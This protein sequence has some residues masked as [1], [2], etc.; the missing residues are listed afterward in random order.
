MEDT[1]TQYMITP[2][3]GQTLYGGKNEKDFYENESLEKAGNRWWR[4]YE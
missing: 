2:K 4:D 1:N 3:P